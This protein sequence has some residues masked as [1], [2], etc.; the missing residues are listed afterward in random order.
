MDHCVDARIDN[1]GFGRVIGRSS[2]FSVTRDK[3]RLKYA[4]GLFVSVIAAGVVVISAI[5][6][7]GL[8]WPSKQG[9]QGEKGSPFCCPEDMRETLRYINTSANPCRDFFAYVCSGVISNRLW[10][11]DNSQAEF[12]RMVFTG[13]MPPGTPRSPAGE[14]LVEF[15]RSC[16]ESIARGEFHQCACRRPRSKRASFPEEHGREESVH[17]RCKVNSPVQA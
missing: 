15:R 12:E 17:L 8:R 16:L 3:F 9:A 7:V 5:V 4:V 6:F 13:V 11:E 1:F 14:F 10:P 2:Q